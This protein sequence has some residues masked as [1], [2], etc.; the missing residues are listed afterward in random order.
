M[1]L[2][3][4]VESLP[5]WWPRAAV[6]IIIFL[7]AMWLYVSTSVPGLIVGSGIE[8]ESAQFQRA[9]YR[10]GIAHS[11]G[12]P[13]QTIIGYVA[14][15]LAELLGQNPYTWITY[16]SS[17]GGA[18]ALVLFFQLAVSISNPSAA[19]ATTGLLA[20]TG[21]M[22]HLST[23]AETQGLHVISVAGIFW[24]IFV[25]LKHPEKF[26]PLAGIALLGGIGLA[27][28]RTIVISGA[29]AALAMLIT[30]SWRRLGPRKWII[31]SAL[32]IIPI[33]SYGY[34][35][36]RATDP[37]VVHSVRETWRPSYIPELGDNY[38]IDFILGTELDFNIRFPVH[39][40]WERLDFVIST[41][42]DQLTM[43][44]VIAGMGGLT[45]LSIKQ[46]KLSIILIFYLI[47]WTLLL[48]SWRLDWKATIYYHALLIPLIIGLAYLA[49]WPT[50]NLF[51]RFPKRYRQS[52]LGAVFSVPLFAFFFSTY[53]TNLPDR[54]LSNDYR[55]EEY[56]E[57]MEILPGHSA[58]FTGGWSADSFILLEYIDNSGRTDVS[59]F[60]SHK[61]DDLVG[62]L[63]YRPNRK[64][65]ISHFLR[66]LWGMYGESFP[67]PERGLAL[68]GTHTELLLQAR[69][70]HD[71]ELQLEADSAEFQLQMPIGTE[72]SLYSFTMNP[73]AEGLR[74]GV[75]WQATNNSGARYS[76]Y[77]HLRYYGNECQWDDSVRLL[78]Q[79]DSRDP[80]DG[81]Y[82]TYFWEEGEIV[83][84]T[85]LIPWPSEPLPP[86]GVSLTVGLTLNGERMESEYCLPLQGE[87]SYPLDFTGVGIEVAP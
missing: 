31:L 62:E 77:T 11:T 71:P 27:N 70:K 39:D 87:N 57:Q 26:A 53:V 36:W 43:P 86:S 4:K 61:A 41:L 46:K 44:G 68:S 66:A 2:S 13:I 74:L 12:Y 32:V 33:M 1:S 19:L 73:T 35:F 59:I 84:D 49:S 14:G 82:P 67:I 78:A 76:T 81:T 52:V 45:L 83:K 50:E 23:I 8:S 28:H 72:I 64:I 75:Y 15:Q 47:G 7:A 38:L 42:K 9:A 60:A 22:W 6:S 30:G 54:D 37:H 20:V 80:V 16:T 29:A 25:H 63:A 85:Y 3:Q 10:L 69:Q 56:T 18:I 17:L 24:L 21:T 51:R 58:V 48:M 40:F 34:I 55:G 79:H 5:R 65:F